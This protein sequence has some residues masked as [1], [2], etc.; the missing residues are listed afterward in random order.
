MKY[1]IK[2]ETV[3]HFSLFASKRTPVVFFS[4]FQD[5]KWL[6]NQPSRK[7]AEA[8]IKE[9]GRYDAGQAELRQAAMEGRI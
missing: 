1:T 4:I 8:S 3:I 6:E 7:D 2:K 9:W 5:G